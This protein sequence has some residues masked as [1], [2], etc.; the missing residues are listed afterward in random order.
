M[1]RSIR[2]LLTA[3]VALLAVVAYAQDWRTSYEAGLSHARANEWSLARDAF[4]LAGA[5]RPDQSG[6]TNL[7]GPPTERRQW[8]DGAP[9]SPTFLAAYSAY[10]MALEA[11]TD[12]ERTRLYNEA[13]TDFE[14][15]VEKNQLSPEVFYYLNVLYGRVGQAERKAALDDR[16]N[17]ANGR[18]SWRV[19]TVVLAPDEVAMMARTSSAARNGSAAQPIATRR[20]GEAAVRVAPGSVLSVPTKYALVVGNV[21][22]DGHRVGFA[23]EDATRIRDSI[24]MNAG[25]PDENVV[26]L[27]DASVDEL[28]SAV[29]ELAARIPQ[30][31]TVF[32]YF[33]GV[34]RNVEGRDYLLG[35]DSSATDAATMLPKMDL[36]NAFSERGANV[37]AFYQAA[38]PV[39]D[40]RYFGQEIPGQG[41]IAQMQSTMPGSEVASMVRDGRATGVFTD[42]MAGVMSDLRSNSLP[43]LEFA[44]QVFYRVRRGDTGLTGGGSRQT[45]TLPVFHNIAADARF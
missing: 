4:R 18:L 3:L 8:R 17:R 12:E 43:V 39:I 16:Y 26:M 20:A 2:S 22:P 11:P 32:I 41:R 13:I 24:V 15:M 28:R 19:D 31:A 37:F 7:P 35:S 14:A 33:S 5:G 38:R 27:Q 21:G 29:A 30:D 6:P 23:A 42:A 34:G 44:W 45:P 25:Y 9:Y 40:G 36:Y 1:S 10:R